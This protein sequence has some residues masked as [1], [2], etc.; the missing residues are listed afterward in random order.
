MIHITR[1]IIDSG[2]GRETC[3]IRNHLSEVKIDINKCKEIGNAPSYMPL[4]THPVKELLGM[5][6]SA[7]TLMQRLDP[8][9]FIT[10]AQFDNFRR[11]RSNFYTVCKASIKGVI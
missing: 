5:G 1:C 10:F 3:T 8:G 6:P 7:E 2:W 4:G 11:Y 9:R